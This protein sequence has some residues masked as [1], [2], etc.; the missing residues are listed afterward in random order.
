MKKFY[1]SIILLFISEQSIAKA[2]TV[3]VIDV[4]PT[5]GKCQFFF[6]RVFEKI[7]Q[8]VKFIELPRVRGLN[9]L[10]NG[11]IDGDC[12]LSLGFSKKYPNIIPIPEVLTTINIYLLGLKSAEE[13]SSL[14]D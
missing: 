12:G 11:I 6:K 4:G 10:N 14:D 2:F 8:N 9:E 5:K 3:N 13:I 1:I 7:G